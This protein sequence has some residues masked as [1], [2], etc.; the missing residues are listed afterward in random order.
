MDAIDGI[1]DSL[2]AGGSGAGDALG[3]TYQGGGSAGARSLGSWYAALASAW[4]GSLDDQAGRITELSQQLS[5]GQDMPSQTAE[6]TAE[7]MRMQF[8]SNSASTSVK[9]VG[10]ALEALARKQ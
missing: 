10:Q 4:G 5:E 3:G 9:A 8:M 6:L 7:S 1:A 2:K